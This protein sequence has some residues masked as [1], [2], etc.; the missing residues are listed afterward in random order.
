[1][2]DLRP[3]SADERDSVLELIPELTEIPDE[4]ARGRCVQIWAAA[5]RAGRWPD[6]RVAPTLPQVPVSPHANLV[7]HTRRVLRGCRDLAQAVDQADVHPDVNVLLEAAA[8]HDVGKLLEYE[9]AGDGFRL[10][11]VGRSLPHAAAGAQWA[12]AAGSPEA[13]AR[14]VYVHTPAVAAVPETIEAVILFA[15]DQVDADAT[16]MSAGEQPS[17]KRAILGGAATR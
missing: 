17:A 13:V 10:S 9:A 7:A 15:V 5:I 14:A 4:A 16:R 2:I 1:M 8:L 3:P 12:L 6:P 11:V